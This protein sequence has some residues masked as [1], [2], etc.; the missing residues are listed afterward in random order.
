[1]SQPRA[2]TIAV[3]NSFTLVN[4]YAGKVKIFTPS[5]SFFAP[6]LI[7]CPMVSQF[8][9]A[10]YHSVVQE[11]MFTQGQGIRRHNQF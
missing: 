1:M 2:I 10:S 11:T 3:I 9:I 8:G 4:I 5:C 6:Y 7:Q